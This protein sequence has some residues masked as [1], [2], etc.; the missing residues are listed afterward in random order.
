MAYKSSVYQKAKKALDERR[1]RALNQQ[2]QRHSAV[3]LKCP[4]LFEIEREMSSYGV[5]VAKSIGMG[6]DAE[7]YVRKLSVKSLQVQKRRKEVLKNAGFPD[8]YLDVK[9]TCP[10]CQDTGSHDGYY[11]ECYKQLI[12]ETAR[13]ELAVSSTLKK[14]TFES[15]SLDYYP[16]VIDTILGI[17]QREQM[18]DVFEYCREY[19][20]NFSKKS[21]G[22]IMLGQTGLGKTHLSLAIA[23]EV[24]DRGYNVYYNS[25]QNIMD[26]LQKEHFGR[27]TFDESISES[28]F[29]S[30]LLI[31]DDLGAEFV[32]QF[33]VAELYN[34]INTRINN[35]LPT[36]ISTNLT[37]REI[38]EKYTH[39]IA[40]RIVGSSMP[41]QFCGKDIRQL[42]ED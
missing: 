8:D 25:V 22:I 18:S 3:L 32:T 20:K 9:Y 34:I 29:E 28:L 23:G 36:I 4:E 17:S 27:G 7:E 26:R 5:A 19:A 1:A 30:D 10:I 40:S 6:A 39:R 2:E 14:S 35:D 33:T 16:D 31:L 24:I 13:N 21:C 42:K 37:M 12:R 38:E 41:V 11:C 15:F